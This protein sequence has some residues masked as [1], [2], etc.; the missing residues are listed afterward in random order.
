M[1]RDPGD[2]SLDLGLSEEA[3]HTQAGIACAFFNLNRLLLKLRK[4]YNSTTN[5]V[6][7]TVLRN[8]ARRQISRNTDITRA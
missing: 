4:S 8:T 5:G 3:A 1:H 2:A 7:K 6:L